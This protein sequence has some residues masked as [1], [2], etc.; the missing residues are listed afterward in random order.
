MRSD[1][2]YVSKRGKVRV[3]SGVVDGKST[4]LGTFK[5]PNSKRDAETFAR[6]ARKDLGISEPKPRNVITPKQRLAALVKSRKS[7]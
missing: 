1:G 6:K 4:Y 3:V 7:N 5:G 2:I